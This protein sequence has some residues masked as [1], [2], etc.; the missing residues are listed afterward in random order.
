MLDEVLSAQN[1]LH[2]INLTRHNN[3]LAWLEMRSYLHTKGLIIF[4]RQEI[5]VIFIIVIDVMLAIFLLY[6]LMTSGGSGELDTADT[7]GSPSFMAFAYF[8]LLCTYALTRILKTTRRIEG[9]QRKQ[10]ALLA[11]Q[12]FQIYYKRITWHPPED[13]R[14]D[15]DDAD[16]SF[17]EGD[18][19][20]GDHTAYQ[21]I[22]EQS[23]DDD[24]DDDDDD[25][26]DLDA[27]P[28]AGDPDD[29]DEEDSESNSE[30]IKEDGG[31][32]DGAATATTVPTDSAKE[33][34]PA[35]SQEEDALL[36]SNRQPTTK[37]TKVES[38]S[39][40][41]RPAHRRA[42]THNFY[43]DMAESGQQLFS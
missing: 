21:P 7:F 19:G 34:S 6:R 33:K 1:Q 29:D 15:L 40:T 24:D 20:D 2:Y 16:D 14:E 3:M 23:E 18:P 11:A 17:S 32:G 4:S 35:T 36:L 43:N 31:A 41:N 25:D 22:I 10:I 9:L 5:F 12:K 30:E 27:I 26:I 13:E 8:F 39:G 38:R 37:L 42:Q 28:E